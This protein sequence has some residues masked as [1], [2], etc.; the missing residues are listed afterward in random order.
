VF[1]GKDGR[2]YA[3]T[4]TED[5]A[6]GARIYAWDVTDQGRVTLTDSVLLQ[7]A[8]VNEITV[9][10]DAS[11]ALVARKPG[12]N[13]PGAIT[14]LDISTPAHPRVLAEFSEGMAGG[15]AAAWLLAPQSIALLAEAASGRL[16]VVDFADPARPRSVRVWEHKPGAAQIND[17]WSD[18][19]HA[20]LAYGAEGL[21]ILDVGDDGSPSNPK[22]VSQVSWKN[23]A[24]SSVFRAGR[25][26]YL[27]ENVRGCPDCINGPRGAVRVIDAQRLNEPREVAAFEVP[28]AGAGHVWVENSVLYAAY[29]QGGVRIVDVAGELRRDL[30]R[31]G[32]QAGWFVTSA[33]TESGMGATP[34]MA[35]AAMPFKGRLYVVDANSGLWVLTHQRSARLT[36]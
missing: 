1:A 24:A 28:E 8:G 25:Y 15:V 5:P 11:W 34:S 35:V 17:V 21:V 27:A 22:L 20:Y 23:A 30:Y 9:N 16:H 7:S 6:G 33:P 4:G 26:V 13:G 19:K 29:R 36:Q 31:Q 18:G 32:R 10:A 2:D 3:Y 14:V 12:V